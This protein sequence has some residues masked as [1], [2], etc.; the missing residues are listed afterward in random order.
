MFHSYRE[1]RPKKILYDIIAKGGLIEEIGRRGGGEKE[2]AMREYDRSIF[3]VCV[4]M[5]VCACVCV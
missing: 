3:Y 4:C 1:S 5:C 2:R